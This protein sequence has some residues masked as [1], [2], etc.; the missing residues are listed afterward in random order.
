MI[1]EVYLPALRHRWT[2]WQNFNLSR[3]Q[4]VPRYI[5]PPKVYPQLVRSF[6]LSIN[7]GPQMLT[8][9]SMATSHLLSILNVPNVAS[10]TLEID[11]Y[12]CSWEGWTVGRSFPEVKR[13]RCSYH[14]TP[15][16]ISCFN[17][18]KFNHWWH[19]VEQTS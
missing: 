6:R 9:S 5:T 2:V 10:G 13:L 14:L 15:S 8:W 1:D 18:R 19:V 11:A 16:I 4:A 7:S 3:Y 12:A 17:L